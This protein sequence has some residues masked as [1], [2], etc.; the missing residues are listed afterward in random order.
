MRFRQAHKAWPVVDSFAVSALDIILIVLGALLLLALLF[1]AGGFI[2]AKRRDSEHAGAYAQHVAEADRALEAARAE[3][4]GWHRDALESAAKAAL[5]RER[6][7]FLIEELHLILVDDRPGVTEDR[8]RFVAQAA[9]EEL[10][11]TLGRA[12]GGDWQLEKVG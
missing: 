8:A 9:G 12:E 3:D 1:L 5:R 2:A 11:L 6:P 7:D 10:H 4:K